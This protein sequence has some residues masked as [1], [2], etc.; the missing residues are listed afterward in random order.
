MSMTPLPAPAISEIFATLR[1]VTPVEAHDLLDVLERRLRLDEALL[2]VR[3]HLDEEED[4]YSRKVPDVPALRL[5]G[6][7]L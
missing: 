7:D 1:S 6:G 3:E 4:V 5:V 2:T